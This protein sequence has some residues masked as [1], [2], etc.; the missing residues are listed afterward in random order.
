MIKEISLHAPL[1]AKR[2]RVL[3]I[4]RSLGMLTLSFASFTVEERLVAGALM[5][6]ALEINGLP[7]FHIFSPFQDFKGQLEY[8]RVGKHKIHAVTNGSVIQSSFDICPAE[9]FFY[10]SLGALTVDEL[11]R[12]VTQK[13]RSWWKLAPPGYAHVFL[14]DTGLMEPFFFYAPSHSSLTMYATPPRLLA[15]LNAFKPFP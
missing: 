7:Y 13:A 14:K 10:F 5:Y 9:E 3:G 11:D 15:F 2:A 8:Q 12:K 6:D 1:G 4:P